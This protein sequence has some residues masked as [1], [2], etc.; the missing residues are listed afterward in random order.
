MT[1]PD[2]HREVLE[3]LEDGVLVVGLGGRIETLN[4]AAERILG[5]EA[6][7]AAGRGFAE[8]FILR[9]G[10][11][12]FTQLVIDA[13]TGEAGAQR[14]VV[15]VQSIGGARALSVATSYLR[16]PGAD[17][18][19]EAVAAIAVF[20]DI[21]ELREL[22]ETELRLAKEAEA[23]HHRLQDAY[24]EIEDRNAALASALRKVRVVQGLGMA[25][26]VGLFVAAGFWTTHSLDL[27]EGTTA[28][29][30]AVPAG[31]GTRVT[32]R[33]RRVRDGI[34]LRGTLA[35]WR[36]V[37]V[38]SPIDADIVA[39]HFRTGQEVA[40]GDVLL[41]LDLVRA[42]QK[43]AVARARQAE[44]LKRVRSLEDWENSPEMVA[45][46]RSFTKTRL[47]MEGERRKI[48]KSRFLFEEGLI[49]T[50]DHE[51]AERQ[52]RGQELD[53]AAAEEEFAAIRA[54]ASEEALEDARLALEA[55]RTEFRAAAEALRQ[56]AVRAPI[57]GVVLPATRAGREMTAIN[58]VQRGQEL[59]G[60]GDFSRMAASVK[61]DE[62]DVVSL[63]AGQDV[64]VTGN[65]FQGLRLKGEVTYVSSQANAGSGGIPKFDMRVTLDPVGPTVAARLR[66]GM[67]A[68]LRI[69]TYDNPAALSVPLAAVISNNHVHVLRVI[70]PETGDIEKRRVEIGPT[71]RESVEIRA[72]LKPGETVLVPGG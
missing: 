2:I 46:R 22:R 16:R 53:F 51:D 30:A 52:F 5:L 18:S 54:Q 59:L 49:S 19:S 68:R 15:E 70:D 39:M 36:V 6:G 7:E 12:D 43:Y 40:K 27:F 26:A 32:V 50:S 24:R 64:T 29:A 44:A 41:E 14:H 63:R 9:E 1:G 31:D 45:A 33:P 21:T 10:F 3:N 35:P 37:T 17:G 28:E 48:N 42:K 55:A 38:R 47:A 58:S 8:L 69:V 65:A 11:D 56:D 25:L 66:S 4:P 71:A 62:S 60:I 67:S 23:Q 61:V 57:A 20:S 13:T 34:T 72:G